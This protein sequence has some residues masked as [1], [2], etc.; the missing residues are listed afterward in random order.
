VAVRGTARSERVD[1]IGGTMLVGRGIMDWAYWLMN[2]AVRGF[3]ALGVTPNK[4][5]FASLALG[6]GAGVALGFDMFGLACLLATLS[7]LGDVLDGQIA[8]L[9]NTGS[10]KGELLDAAVDR[11]T[12]FFFL[13]GLLVHYRDSVPFMGLTMG[14]MLASFM[15]SYASAKAEALQLSPPRGLMRRHERAVYLLA[16][17]G[18]TSL[19]GD[20]L[21]D[22]WTELPQ[23]TPELVALAAVAVIG[24]YAAVARFVRIGRALR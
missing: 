20:W 14:A 10:D 17:A 24:N 1:K 5:T 8:R 16:G 15:I 22:R 18:L 11:Y 13:F 6:A 19:F 4:I 23:S 3:A 2:P 9:T 12:E 7:T 21:H